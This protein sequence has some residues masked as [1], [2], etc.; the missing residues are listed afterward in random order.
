MYV[1]E[2]EQDKVLEIY[3]HQITNLTMKTKKINKNK[4]DLPI[5]TEKITFDVYTI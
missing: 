4:K 5:F 1:T 2:K 3:V